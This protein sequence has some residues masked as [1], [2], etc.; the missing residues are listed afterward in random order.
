METARLVLQRPRLGD[1]EAIFRTYSSDPDVTRFLSWPVH[2]SIEQTRAFLQWSDA[3]WRRWPAGPY[4]IFLR[5]HFALVGGT[6]IGFET[7]DRASTGYVLAKAAWGQ[8]YAT[9]ALTA[10]VDIARQVGVQALGAICHVDHRASAH[11]LEKCGFACEG[12]LRRFIVFP[13]VS[14][15]DPCD[16]LKYS[17]RL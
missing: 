2:V 3:E 17:R 7:P 16:V 6:G 10:V 12:T 4:L 5:A 8:G 1:A 13:N 9:E 14:A 11:V 15:I